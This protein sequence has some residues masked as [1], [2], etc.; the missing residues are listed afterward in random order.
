MMKYRLKRALFGFFIGLL[1]LVSAADEAA[2]R[3]MFLGDVHYDAKEYHTN[4]RTKAFKRNVAM[5]KNATP[6]LLEA[7]S[8][9]AAK[10]NVAFV[11]QLGDITQGDADTPELQE[12]MFRTAFSILKRNFPDRQLLVIKGNHDVRGRKFKTDNGPA[13]RALLP[14][15]ASEL[16]VPKLADGLRT[17]SF[18]PRWT[19]SPSPG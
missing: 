17:A 12:K 10:E 9:E 14:L 7:A 4:Y 11:V 18:G 16:K 3:A 8:A 5:W 15:V 6:Q 1:T 19:V 13:E 2:Y